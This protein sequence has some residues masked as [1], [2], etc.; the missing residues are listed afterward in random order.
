MTQFRSSLFNRIKNRSG[1]AFVGF[2]Y[3]FVDIFVV[4]ESIFSSFCVG[5]GVAL[6][7]SYCHRVGIRGWDSHEVG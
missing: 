3:M 1:S 6:R 4:C 5:F 7:W 2:F